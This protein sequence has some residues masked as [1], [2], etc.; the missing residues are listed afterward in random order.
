MHFFCSTIPFCWGVHGVLRTL[1]EIKL[2][3][4]R[5][6]FKKSN[7]ILN[8]TKWTMWPQTPL[9]T[10]SKND[11][12]CVKLCFGKFDIECFPKI[13]P[14]QRFEVEHFNGTKTQNKKLILHFM[15]NWKFMWPSPW[16]HL[17]VSRFIDGEVAKKKNQLIAYSHHLL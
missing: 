2:C 1:H 12:A 5:N 15:E 9:W 6:I 4:P 16:C 7:K 14:T 3:K 11:E 8:P 10:K 13:H 17:M